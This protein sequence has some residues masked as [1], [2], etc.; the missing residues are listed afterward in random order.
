VRIKI[1]VS[2]TLLNKSSKTICSFYKT[3]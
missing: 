1:K 3:F 2:I